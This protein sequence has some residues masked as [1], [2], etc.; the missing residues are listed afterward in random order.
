MLVNP[1]RI[2]SMTSEVTVWW[3]RRSQ[4]TG[5]VIEQGRGNPRE[6]RALQSPVGCRQIN[7]KGLQLQHPDLKGSEEGGLRDHLYFVSGKVRTH[8]RAVRRWFSC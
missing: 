7:G 1:L 5:V 4:A 3:R 6:E 2:G 8:N